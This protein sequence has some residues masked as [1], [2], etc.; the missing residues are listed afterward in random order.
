MDTYEAECVLARSRI[1][2]LGR[3]PDDFSFDISLLPPD[4]DAGGMYT[5]Q[6]DV[7]ISSRATAKS[8]SATGGIGWDWVSVAAA[9][10]DAG[11][12]D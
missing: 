1:S 9:A 8:M 6:Y 12:L 7:K 4:P 2:E 10:I 3:D 5:V 11:K